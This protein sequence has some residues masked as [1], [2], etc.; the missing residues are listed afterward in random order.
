MINSARLTALRSVLNVMPYRLQEHRLGSSKYLFLQDKEKQYRRE[1]QELTG[2]T[3]VASGQSVARE[4]QDKP[5]LTPQNIEEEY[6][7]PDG[8]ILPRRRGRSFIYPAA[9]VK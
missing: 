1:I 2:T 8:F 9:Y 7:S 3:E 5:C 6:P 4:T